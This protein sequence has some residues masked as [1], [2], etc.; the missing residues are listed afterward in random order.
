MSLFQRKQN[1]FYYYNFEVSAKD[2]INY[3]NYL[4]DINNGAKNPT[5][6]PPSTLSTKIFSG[7]TTDDRADLQQSASDIEAQSGTIKSKLSQAFE[8]VGGGTAEVISKA[9][10]YFSV[11]PASFGE[12]VWVSFLYLYDIL[13]ILYMSLAFNIQNAHPDDASKQEE[14]L[15]ELKKYKIVLGDYK[16]TTGQIINLGELPINFSVFHEWYMNNIAK[17]DVTNYTLQ[18]FVYSLFNDIVA[19]SLGASCINGANLDNKVSIGF[20]TYSLEHLKNFEPLKASDISAEGGYVNLSDQASYEFY[21]SCLIAPDDLTTEKETTNYLYIYS[22]QLGCELTGKIID[23]L[24]NGIYHFYIGQ[25][26]GIHKS[27]KFKRIDQPYLKEARA[28]KEDSFVLGQ[29]RE[30]YNVDLTTVGNTVF[31]PG[32]VIYI[33]PPI[34]FGAV[35][36]KNNFAYLM[37]IGGYYSVIKVQSV[38]DQDKFETSLECVYLSSGVCEEQDLCDIKDNDKV[39][40]EA[41]IA[42]LEALNS[43]T[44]E[45]TKIDS[46][47]SLAKSNSSAVV[48]ANLEKEAKANA[49]QLVSSYS[50]IVEEL[51]QQTNLK[52][53]TDIPTIVNTETGKGTRLI[54]FERD[55]NG[56]AIPSAIQLESGYIEDKLSI[57][58]RTLEEERK[59]GE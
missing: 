59:R 2:I 30:V 55:P 5:L 41:V 26:E 57:Y 1:N 3:E 32:M 38:I 48:Y 31:Y 28:T 52:L 22:K 11:S 50:K 51:N 43:I 33:H 44:K 34:E 7:I 27:I 36:E 12:N 14:L 54:P 25:T 45:L 58:R 9:G 16:T 23:D 18:S 6:L 37:G 17:T 39:K 13:N 47:L 40:T 46:Y 35:T 19:K 49:T 21:T 20:V 42:R 8:Y 15:K 4:T 29:L 24:K 56:K 10:E 53:A